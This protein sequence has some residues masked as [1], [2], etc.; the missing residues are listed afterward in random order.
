MHSKLWISFLAVV[1]LVVL[2]QADESPAK[3][4]DIANNWT[5]DVILRSHI[6]LPTPRPVQDVYVMLN[7]TTPDLV[8]RIE[9]RQAEDPLNLEKETFATTNE[10]PHDP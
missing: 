2:V 5:V 7:N 8:Y 10:T 3:P 4:V 1:L 9:R 6:Y